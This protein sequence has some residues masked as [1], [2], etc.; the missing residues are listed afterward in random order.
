LERGVLLEVGRDLGQLACLGGLE[1]G[2]VER[3]PEL[4][5]GV[6]AIDDSG[7]ALGAGG[8]GWTA[9]ASGTGVT[10]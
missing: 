4:P 6:P 8:S 2:L 9:N 1:L 10:G 3:E 5:I 7:W